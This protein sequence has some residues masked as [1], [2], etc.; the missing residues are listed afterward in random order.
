MGTQNVLLLRDNHL[1]VST[2]PNERSESVPLALVKNTSL[3]CHTLWILMILLHSLFGNW[4]IPYLE[5]GL[6]SFSFFFFENTNEL[7][8]VLGFVL[9][10]TRTTHSSATRWRSLCLE[11]FY[12]GGR[13]SSGGV[14]N[15]HMHSPVIVRLRRIYGGKFEISIH[16]LGSKVT[17]PIKRADDLSVHLDKCNY[18][19]SW[20]V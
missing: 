6:Q 1:S 11:C 9:S 10:Y 2:K 15:D 20:N 12:C 19:I 13:R 5:L 8:R 4:M 3:P 18:L 14:G 17:P 7:F 16:Y